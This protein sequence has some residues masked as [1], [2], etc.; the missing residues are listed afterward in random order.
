[1]DLPRTHNTLQ[2]KRQLSKGVAEKRLKTATE[3][4]AQFDLTADRE[5]FTELRDVLESLNAPTYLDAGIEL[6][7][8]L[9]QMLYRTQEKLAECNFY[10]LKHR[11]KMLLEYSPDLDHEVA[12]LS[13]SINY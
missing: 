7:L 6:L 13:L 4:V 10:Q 11:N 12:T 3:L 2:R 8:K 9:K 1:M 5:E